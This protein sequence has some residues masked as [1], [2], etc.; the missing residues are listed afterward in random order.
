M[1]I[2]IIYVGKI[3]KQYIK[4]GK[5][6]FALRISKYV[7]LNFFYVKQFSSPDT[8]KN[9]KNEEVLILKLIRNNFTILCDVAGKKINSLTFAKQLKYLLET[10]KTINFIIGSSNGVSEYIKKSVDLS[11]SFSQMTFPH[12][13]FMLFLLEQIYRSFKILNNQKYHK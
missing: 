13:L 6:D 9:F 8:K 12:S 5:D 10:K 2:N 4:V 7:N 3:T 11:F 1:T